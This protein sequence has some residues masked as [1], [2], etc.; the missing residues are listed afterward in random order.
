MSNMNELRARLEQLE[1]L[2]QARNHVAEYAR[3]VDARET[4]ALSKLFAQAGLLC[5]PTADHKGQENIAA[6]FEARIHNS[7]K[8]HFITN[9]QPRITGPREVTVESYFLFTSQ[10]DGLSGLGWGTYTDVIEFTDQGPVF[11]QKTITPIV[12]STIDRGWEL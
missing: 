7:R 2:E 1:M 9:V 11:I 5:V 3:I 6:F 4:E 8:R 10:E 12:N